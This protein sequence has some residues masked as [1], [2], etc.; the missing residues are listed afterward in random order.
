MRDAVVGNVSRILYVL[1]AAVGVVLLIACAD[2]ACLMLTRAASREREMAIRA[3]LGAGR[4]RVMRLVLVET[5]VLAALGGARD[6]RW[7]GG[8]QRALLAAAPVDDSARA[9][10]RVRRPR[11]RCSPRGVT[12]TAALV[13]G[14]LPAIESSRRDSRARR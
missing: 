3:A 6:W 8:A 5:G 13:C 4:G 11:A 10:N 7:R 9:G 1:L 14:L 12:V 2:I